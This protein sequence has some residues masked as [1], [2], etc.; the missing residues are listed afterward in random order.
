ML[1]KIIKNGF[2]EN[3]FPGQSRLSFKGFMLFLF[4]TPLCGLY[5]SESGAYLQLNTGF[6]GSLTLPEMTNEDLQYLNKR[7]TSIS[8]TVSNLLIGGE[9]EA[10]YIFRS[11]DFFNLSRQNPFSG[12]GVFAY[13]GFS[14]GNTSQK[15]TAT[16]NGESFD[17]FTS[18]DFLPVIDFGI[19]EKNYFFNNKMAIGIGIGGR[20]ITDMSPEYMSYSTDPTIIPTEV[21]TIIVTEDMMKK[22]NPLMFSSKMIIEYNIPVLPATELVLGGYFRYNVYRPKYLTV[23]P[24]L[25]DMAKK[26]NSNFDV[27]R[28]FP[29]YW[30]N[31]FDFGIKMGLLFKL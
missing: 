26:D 9:V 16:Q 2:K 1:K 13:L 23:P 15:I 4:L 10:G 14:Q 7:A 21:G 8:G 17:I 5:S 6:S 31:S 27:N 12:V 30:I 25:A 24:K 3:S 11:H 22:M 29:D 19:V 18:V 20:A 28:E